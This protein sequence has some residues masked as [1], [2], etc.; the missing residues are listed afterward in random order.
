V[1]PAGRA[2][3][4]ESFE[5]ERVVELSDDLVKVLLLVVGDL[6]G[7]VA[8]EADRRLFPENPCEGGRATTG[9]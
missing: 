1:S 5:I 3:P 9:W 4:S 7:L 6:E 2:G 8:I